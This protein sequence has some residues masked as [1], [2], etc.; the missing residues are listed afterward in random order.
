MLIFLNVIQ[1]F[2]FPSDFF[3][4]PCSFW[5]TYTFLLKTHNEE[6]DSMEESRTDDAV[7]APE[8]LPKESPGPLAL[9][10]GRAK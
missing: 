5:L 8:L 4:T 3:H 9:S 10:V 1:T 2:E 7:Y 6:S